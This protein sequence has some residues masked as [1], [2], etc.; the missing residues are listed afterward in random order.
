VGLED[1]LCFQIYKP[2]LF[3]LRRMD[4]F[5]MVVTNYCYNCITSCI[6]FGG[7][8]RH[9]GKKGNHWAVGDDKEALNPEKYWNE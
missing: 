9:P 1:C 4:I 2:V 5:I 7:F 3:G 8:K 6:N